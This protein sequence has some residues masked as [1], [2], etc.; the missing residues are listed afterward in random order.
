MAILP[1]Q[2]Q[3]RTRVSIEIEAQRRELGFHGREVERDLRGH[4]REAALAGFGLRMYERLRPVWF[5]VRVAG[6]LRHL[7]TS[8]K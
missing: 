3:Q 7:K 2:K 4:F 5:I 1:R 8:K 6:Q